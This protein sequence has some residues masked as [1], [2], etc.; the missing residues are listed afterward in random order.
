MDFSRSQ[1]YA[2]LGIGS[3]KSS[4]KIFTNILREVYKAARCLVNRHAK[5]VDV[6]V[7][8]DKKIEA[9]ASAVDKAA[10]D[11]RQTATND[12]D[13]DAVGAVDGDMADTPSSEAASTTTDA[14]RPAKMRRRP[15][16]TQKM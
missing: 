10:E 13:R 5:M 14:S 4:D 12:A 3:L 1:V 16:F 7:W 6:D 8:D 9:E 2:Q 15:M 11:A